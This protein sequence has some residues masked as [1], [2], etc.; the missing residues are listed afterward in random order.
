[1]ASAARPWTAQPCDPEVSADVFRAHPG[2]HADPADG[3]VAHA[4]IDAAA[5]AEGAAGPLASHAADAQVQQLWVETNT[6]ANPEWRKAAKARRP[7]PRTA[8]RV[9]S[10]ATRAASTRAASTRAG[11]T[12]SA[13]RAEAS[14]GGGAADK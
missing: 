8:S 10:A 4:A 2:T 7:V 5:P 13:A 6:F 3:D 14:A 1:V 12:R 11:R 9:A